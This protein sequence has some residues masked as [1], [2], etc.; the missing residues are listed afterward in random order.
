L[1]LIGVRVQVIG[2]NYIMTSVMI[3]TPHYYQD[4]K[5]EKNEIVRNIARVGEGRGVYRVLVGNLK[6]RDHWGDPGI[7]GRV[8]LR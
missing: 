2:E 3:C 7:D 4:V 1:G 5:I 6:E 8:I